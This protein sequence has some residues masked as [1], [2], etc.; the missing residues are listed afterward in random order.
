[1][2][3]VMFRSSQMLP[4]AISP[5]S[6]TNLRSSRL[7]VEPLRR[8]LETAPEVRTLLTPVPPLPE[9]RAIVS[10][11]TTEARKLDAL[12]AEAQK[13]IDLLQERRTAFISAVVTGQIDVRKLAA[14]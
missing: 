10:W 7:L 3:F 5:A 14:A 1:M 12:A 11:I 4:L 9:Q 13:A 2:N 8:W 6:H